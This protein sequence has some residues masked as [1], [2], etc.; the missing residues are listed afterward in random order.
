M[1]LKDLVEKQTNPSVQKETNVL[2]MDLSDSDAPNHRKGTRENSKPP[3][4]RSG[5]KHKQNSSKDSLPKDSEFPSV[6]DKYDSGHEDTDNKEQARK[7]FRERPHKMG[8][9]PPSDP[10]SFD[11]SDDSSDS[12]P[13]FF[14]RGIG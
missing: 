6:F 4:K 3:S 2:S 13:R 11:D 10:S 7:H 1:Y 9:N 8:D 14:R 12:K 5:K